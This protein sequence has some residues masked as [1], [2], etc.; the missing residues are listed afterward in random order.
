MSGGHHV[1]LWHQLGYRAALEQ[2]PAGPF[3]P[4]GDTISMV[5]RSGIRQRSGAGGAWCLHLF[6]P[7]EPAVDDPVFISSAVKAAQMFTTS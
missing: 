7:M 3:L 2:V 5:Q 1:L 4:A 6:L